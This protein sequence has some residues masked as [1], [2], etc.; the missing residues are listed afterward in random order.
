MTLHSLINGK[1]SLTKI[2]SHLLMK[3]AEAR[4]WLKKIPLSL[5]L[6]IANK[7][8]LKWGNNLMKQALLLN[9]AH[10]FNSE[11]TPKITKY[12]Y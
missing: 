8:T 6:L 2:K 10:L 12:Y 1:I 3:L 5:S 4:L 9:K 11:N 7:M